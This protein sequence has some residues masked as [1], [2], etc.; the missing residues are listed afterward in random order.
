VTAATPEQPDAEELGQG[1]PGRGRICPGHPDDRR[2]M[3]HF[4]SSILAISMSHFESPIPA[5]SQFH[6]LPMQSVLRL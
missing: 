4:E 3:S 5:A 1:E 6:Q 2:Y